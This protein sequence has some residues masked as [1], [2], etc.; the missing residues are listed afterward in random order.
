MR[1]TKASP[2]KRLIIA[3][4]AGVI[5][6]VGVAAYAYLKTSQNGT[7]NTS[8]TNYGPATS[9][10]KKTGDTIKQDNVR[11]DNQPSPGSD[12][13]PTPAPLP[14]S[15]KSKVGME[16]TAANQTGETF[17]IRTM[18]QTVTTEGSCSLIMT[19]PNGKRYTQS[20]GVQAG[21]SSSTCQGFNIPMSA[22]S[23]G[24]WSISV[25]FGNTS[26]VASASKE[27]TLQ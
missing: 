25:Q 26:L 21:P 8:D 18:I 23:P 9:D 13:A 22:L 27:V 4:V 17:V 2:N 10:E 19:G 14:D 5:L 20:V 16:I 1:V 12:P 7:S 6:L 3:L 24:A 15:S 11:P